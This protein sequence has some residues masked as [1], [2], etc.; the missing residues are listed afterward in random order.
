MSAVTNMR[1]HGTLLEFLFF[2]IIA[3]PLLISSDE[4]AVAAAG[5]LLLIPLLNYVFTLKGESASFGKVGLCIFS[6][7]IV[8][9]LVVIGDLVRAYIIKRVYTGTIPLKYGILRFLGDVPS[10]RTTEDEHAK[11]AM[12]SNEEQHA[13]NK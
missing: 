3:L 5:L 13:E 4:R 11:K 9:V 2:L 8:F 10:L 12:D 7:G 1:K 6:F